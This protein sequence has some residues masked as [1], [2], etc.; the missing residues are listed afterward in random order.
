MKRSLLLLLLIVS[1][2]SHSQITL[3]QTFNN[4]DRML[5]TNLGGNDYKFIMINYATSKIDIYNP[6]FSPYMLNVTPALSLGDY[7]IAYFSKSLFDCDDTTLEY[8]MVD[9]G[10]HEFKVFRIDGTLLF[11]KG[12][13]VAPYCFGC[14]NGS[15]DIKPIV[16][17]PDGT[18][19][20]LKEPDDPK[21]YVYSLCGEIPLDVNEFPDSANDM[22]ISPVPTS[23]G[24]DLNFRLPFGFTHGKI[25]VYD[26]TMRLVDEFDVNSQ[27]RFLTKQYNLSS[28]IYTYQLKSNGKTL[29]SGRFI[30]KD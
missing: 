9:W 20:I 25:E 11:E 22:A 30:I 26:N 6:D 3:E 23:R 13:V 19:L 1:S 14:N 10:Y 16:N 7:E 4:V 5:Y 15:A 27:N 21:F 17:T 2:A 8:A 28:G 18:K 29:K 24:T 12:N